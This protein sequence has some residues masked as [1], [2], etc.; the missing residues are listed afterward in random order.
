MLEVGRG[1]QGLRTQ[2]LLQ[3][4]AHGVADRSAGLAIDPLVA[5]AD[6]AIHNEFLHLSN[7]EMRKTNS[8]G[9][10]LF[11]PDGPIASRSSKKLHERSRRFHLT[12]L[13]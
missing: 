10:K 5:V 7:L 13:I 8:S 6:S 2:V 11:R 3:P 9:W 4:F 1:T 12:T